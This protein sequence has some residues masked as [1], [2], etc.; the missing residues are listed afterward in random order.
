MFIFGSSLLVL[1]CATALKSLSLEVTSSWMDLADH[2]ANNVAFPERAGA[3]RPQR[4]PTR[5]PGESR[6]EPDPR[7]RSHELRA[8]DPGSLAASSRPGKGSGWGIIASSGS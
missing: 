4:R 5:G 3:G 6:G 1:R 8:L 2:P 7:T